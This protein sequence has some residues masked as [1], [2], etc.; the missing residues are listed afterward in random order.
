MV[1]EWEKEELGRLTHQKMQAFSQQKAERDAEAGIQPGRMTLQN[2]QCMKSIQKQSDTKEAKI[3]LLIERLKMAVTTGVQG[4]F[5]PST[6]RLKEDRCKTFGHDLPWGTK[7]EGEFP[8]CLD[9]GA[10]ITDASQLRGA[11]PMAERLK[12]KVPGE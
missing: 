12:F 5:A 7:W 2:L 8:K 3:K 11:V 10:K 1:T 6:Q 9:C 4:L